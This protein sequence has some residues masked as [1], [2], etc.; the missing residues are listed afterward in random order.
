MRKRKGE[1]IDGWINLDKSP[2]MTSTHAVAKIRRLLN[3]QKI[4]HGGTLDP[5]ASGVLPIALGE[6]TKTIPFIQD[7]LK[8]YSFTVSWGE[9][10]DTDDLEG[11]VVRTCY[12]RPQTSDII[13]VLA[14]YIGY[15]LQT[16]PQ[17]SALKID[18]QRAYDLAREGE[19]V[20]LKPREVFVKSLE[21]LEARPDDADFR[22][23][24]GKGTYVRALARDLGRDLGCFGFISALRRE[25]V[26]PLAASGAI[27]LDKLE[28][29]VNSA[30]LDQAL[31][32][33][34]TV[35]DDIPALALREEETARLRNG[36]S[37][38]FISRPDFERLQK[39]GLGSDNE[40]TSVLAVYQGSPVALIEATGTNLRPVR[41]FNL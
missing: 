34:Q 16:P 41:V 10:R 40:A 33:L 28:E 19:T 13:Q 4:G 26:G 21:L 37:L 23:T 11:R 3:A 29:L 38:A 15:L 36:Q 6:A 22:M 32:P 39:A 24:C 18:G 25:K 1:K 30:A 5:L 17:F 35:L 9:E 7:A 31:L 20:D 12:A 2:D 14:R 8:I 27:S